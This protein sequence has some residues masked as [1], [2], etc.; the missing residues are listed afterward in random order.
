MDG[1]VPQFHDDLLPRVGKD[2]VDV[3]LDRTAGLAKRVDIERTGQGVALVLDRLDARLDAGIAF[4]RGDFQPL[5]V[6]RVVA[7]AAVADRARRAGD[8]G[9]EVF[10]AALVD[11]TQLELAV[12]AQHH[13]AEILVRA[14][15]V[16]PADPR[17][18]VALAGRVLDTQLRPFRNR[19]ILAVDLRQVFDGNRVQRVF[20]VDIN[21]QGVEGDDDLLG[22]LARVLLG[23]LELLVLHFPAGVG[24]IG[25]LVDQAGDAHART[26]PGDLHADVRVRL[27]VLLGPRLSEVHHRVG[28]FHAD[29]RAA[30]V[31]AAGA[32]P[33]RLP[34]PANDA[35]K[36]QAITVTAVHKPRS[37]TVGPPRRAWKE[38]RRQAIVFAGHTRNSSAWATWRRD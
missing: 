25:D 31:R 28:P 11:R 21:G 36:P 18:L 22:L 27:V 26:A 5:G 32:P 38:T 2:P 23:A 19:P 37:A 8:Q 6:R 17:D 9:D 24:Q 3:F 30:A 34:Q 14:G 16:L 20:V 15:V 29:D 35:R 4:L 33:G 7:H 10:R 13:L 1:N 12:F